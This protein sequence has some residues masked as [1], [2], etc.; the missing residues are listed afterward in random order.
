MK[1]LQHINF[2]CRTYIADGKTISAFEPCTTAE[3]A[4]KRATAWNAVGTKAEA[5]EVLY[6]WGKREM[7]INHL[8]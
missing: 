7:V 8:S 3:E 5:V 4:V 2:G 6:D 1:N